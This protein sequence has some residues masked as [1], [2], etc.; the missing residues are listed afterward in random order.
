[1]KEYYGENREYFNGDQSMTYISIQFLSYLDSP[2]CYQD[3]MQRSS[4]PLSDISSSSRTLLRKR[5]C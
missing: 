5:N 4:R 2:L 1:M 3:T